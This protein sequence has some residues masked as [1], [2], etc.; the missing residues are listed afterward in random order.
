MA[1]LN[2]SEA[3]NLTTENL[4]PHLLLGL[5]VAVI[6]IVVGLTIV[7]GLIVQM[8]L[9]CGMFLYAKKRM[10]KM[11]VD[12]SDIFRVHFPISCEGRAARSS[13]QSFSHSSF[14]RERRNAKMLGIRSRFHRA[15]VMFSRFF[16]RCLH[17]PSTAPDPIGNPLRSYHT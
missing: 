1:Y 12:L 11:P 17:V 3:M 10:L 9:M 2:L 8:P 6:S 7:G 16:T 4:S 5:V 15:H 13:S 14:K